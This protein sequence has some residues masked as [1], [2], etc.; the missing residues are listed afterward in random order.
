MRIIVGINFEKAS[1][2]LAEAMME[3][4]IERLTRITAKLAD[5]DEVIQKRV[6]QMARD[7]ITKSS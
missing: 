2:A 7:K 5:K 3:N 6:F 1:D 4:N